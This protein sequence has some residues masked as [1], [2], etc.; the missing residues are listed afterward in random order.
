MNIESNIRFLDGYST[1]L[2][3][4]YAS[5][6][7]GGPSR[8]SNFSFLRSK[9]VVGCSNALRRTRKPP[10]PERSRKPR[11]TAG[12]RAKQRGADGLRRRLANSL[13]K[14]EEG[15]FPHRKALKTQRKRKESRRG[16]PRPLHSPLGPAPAG[17]W[18]RNGLKR[19]NP[20]R[21]MVGSR[22]PRTHNIW[23][24]GREADCARLRLT[25][26]E[27]DKLQKKAPKAL[28]SPD[29]E[30]KSAPHRRPR[31]LFAGD[32]PRSLAG[33]TA[34]RS[35]APLARWNSE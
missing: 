4:S 34:Y 9:I 7:N 25:S 5:W 6:R 1:P 21:E 13:P 20:R 35:A 30:L 32:R 12:S 17:K 8:F 14:N 16:E 28:K 2:L 15:N 33:P 29:A 27:S 24:T 26:R 23:Y 22:K 3:G 18:R 11:P 10:C 19:L 31:A